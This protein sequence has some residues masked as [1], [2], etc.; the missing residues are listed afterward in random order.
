MSGTLPNWLENLLGIEATESGQGTV[1]ALEHSWP[2]APWV[3]LLMVAFAVGFVL[4]FYLREAATV[5]RGY[6]LGLAA[7]RLVLVL[8]A[9]LMIA[10]LMLS[11]KRTGLPYVVVVLDDSASMGIIDRYD[12]EQV[13]EELLSRLESVQLEEA[14]RLNLAKS[15]LLDDDGA[16]L[17]GIDSRYKLKLYLLASSARPQTGSVSQ[18]LDRVRALE[19]TGESTRL[20]EGVRAVLNDMR[21][22][23]PTAIV[24][25]SDGIN[26]E[27]AALSEAVDYARR[28]GVPLFTVAVGSE[29]PSRDL[30]VSDLLVDE[31]VFV[32]DV[33]NFE[34]KVAGSGYAGRRVDVV[35]REKDGS[36]P[37]AKITVTLPTDGAPQKVRLPYRPTKVGRFEYVVEVETLPEE[38]QTDNNHQQRIVDVRK[39]QIRVLLVQSY[40]NY[41]FRYLRQLLQRD[42]TVELST[43]LQEADL[44]YAEFDATG[45]RVFPVRREELFEYDAIIFGDVNPSFLSESS[46]SNLAAFVTE[47]GGGLVFIAGPRFTPLLYRD[48]LLGTLMPIDFADA[49]VPSPNEVLAEPYRVQPTELGLSSPTMQLGDTP[50]ETREIWANLPPLY[51]MLETPVLKPAARVL[52]EHPVRLGRN[53]K[54]LPL[55]SM[56]YVGAGKVLLHATDET[57]RWRYR[58]GDVLFARYWVQTLRYL[59]RAKLLGKD[60]SAELSVDRREYQRGESVRLRVRFVDER[61]APAADDGVSVVL[62]REGQ[63]NRHVTLER[64]ATNRG[65]FEGILVKP[66][67]GRYHAWVAT[68]AMEGDPPSTDFQ[69]V[70]PPGEFEQVQAEIAALHT[71]SEQTGGQAVEV[72]DS[73]DLLERLPKGRQVPVE[74]LPPIVLWNKWPVLM[75]FLTL[76][77]GE[78]VLRKRKGM[79]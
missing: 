2:A 46:L 60:R 42:S 68:P 70:A 59:S 62:E 13:Q 4:F 74:T 14:T 58:V 44:E 53:G 71:S 25:L 32:D 35:L 34:F 40:P 73:D 57:W 49:E 52:A 16:L 23:P 7:V 17:R 12:D 45:L 6:R 67:D 51:W 8:L 39:E 79:L 33:V 27:G 64:N 77:V 15:V 38:I 75:L 3:T 1:W 24:L 72:L 9:M 43:V 20:G 50:Q 28:K 63:K 41:E 26:T 11:L 21:G 48:T 76:I 54:R 65:V 61:Q 29:S 69:V 66:P 55:I 10:E 31:V 22:T 47:K 78:W 37:L 56:Q 30:E 19:P 36:E 5:S 18:L